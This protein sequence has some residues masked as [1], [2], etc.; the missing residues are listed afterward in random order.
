[1][2]NGYAPLYS[3]RERIRLALKLAALFLP[4]YLLGH[5]W[6][7]PAIE[8]YSTYA[9]C[10]QYGD[11]N[12]VEVVM[13]GVFVGLPLSCALVVAL[14]LGPRSLRIIRAGQDPLPGEKVLRKTRY[15]Y[16]KMAWLTP[17]LTVLFTLYFV[18]MG[19]WG[20][21][22]A[23]QISRDPAPCSEQQLLELGRPSGGIT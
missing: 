16:G 1:M 2:S 13:Y 18:G 17:I 23:E 20:A 22:R 9:N 19:V 12:G 8:H 21:P 7:L 11:I 15:R 5:Y 6:I 3:K 10:Y 14:A 4:L